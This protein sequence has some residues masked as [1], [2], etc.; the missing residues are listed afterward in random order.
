MYSRSLLPSEVHDICWSPNDAF[1]I[2]ACE[3]GH[4]YLWDVLIVSE[5]E[6]RAQSWHND[7]PTVRLQPVVSW[8]AHS[9]VKGVA[10]DP[11]AK[12]RALLFLSFLPL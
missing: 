11:L 10:W 9:Q 3:D 7:L 6:P 4:L 8:E 2:T 1:V 5:K 12:V